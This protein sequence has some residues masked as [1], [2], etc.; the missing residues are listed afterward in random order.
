MALPSTRMEFKITLCDSERG[1]DL[2]TNL[3]LGRHPSET[4]EHAVLRVLGWCLLHDGKDGL[5][6][7][8]GL[9]DAEGADLLSR[10]GTGRA[11]VWVECGAT[12]WDKVKRVLS[13]NG[14]VAVHG[15][16]AGPK[17]KNDLLAQI[18]DLPRPPKDLG[19]VVLWTIDPAL[20]ASLAKKDD[21]RQRWT[22]TAME[23]HLYVEADGV[24]FDGE[25]IR[26][27]AG[28]PG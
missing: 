26:T 7:G 17:R 9:S 11:T 3:I 25:V 15:V 28:D 4:L 23:G 8:P 24:S 20:V 5:E 1:I 27:G 19:A 13:Q 16:F 14:G 21:R 12:S 10:D 6:L 2:A 18:A 22:V